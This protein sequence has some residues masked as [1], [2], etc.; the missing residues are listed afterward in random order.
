MASIRKEILIESSPETV[1]EAVRDFGAVHRRLFPG[2]L[3]D[4]RLDGEARVV[5]F[6]NGMAVREL[7]VDIDDATRRLVWAAVGASATHHNASVAS[8]T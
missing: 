8:K 2:L 6:A 3:T 1:W 7:L 4:A 5:I